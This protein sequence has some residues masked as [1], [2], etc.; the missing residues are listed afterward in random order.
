MLRHRFSVEDTGK[1]LRCRVRHAGYG[2][3]GTREEEVRLRVMF[4]PIVTISREDSGDSLEE[5]LGWV[6]L[7]CSVESSPASE[8]TWARLDPV[9]GAR[10]TVHTGEELELRP[11]RRDTGGTYICVAR[12]S[13]GESDP[14]QTVVNVL[15]PPSRVVTRPA[16]GTV[17]LQVNNRT[18]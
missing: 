10:T 18:R 14:G 7:R 1:R 15:Y 12:N 8:L 3:V 11:V 5:G 6:R 9:T 16:P 13:V 2:A 17:K 4:R